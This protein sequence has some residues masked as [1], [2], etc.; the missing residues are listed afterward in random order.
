[1]FKPYAYS[2]PN[3]SSSQATAKMRHGVAM[4]QDGAKKPSHQEMQGSHGILI[5]DLLE[6]LALDGKSIEDRTF[7]L[8]CLDHRA[9]PYV[10]NRH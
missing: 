10:H 7:L 1:M 6:H 8:S 9:V 2:E 4:V 3:V 5:M